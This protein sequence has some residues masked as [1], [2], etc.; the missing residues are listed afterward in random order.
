MKYVART[1]EVIEGV[2]QL[3]EYA[4]SEHG[5]GDIEGIWIGISDSVIQIR[6]NGTIRE[7][8]KQSELQG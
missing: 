4:V 7:L 1:G 8:I 3:W 5:D 6:K 2:V